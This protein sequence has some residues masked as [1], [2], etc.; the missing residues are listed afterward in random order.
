MVC[1]GIRSLMA[2]IK[3]AHVS[4]GLLLSVALMWVCPILQAQV[5]EHVTAVQPAYTTS[6]R[7]ADASELA[8]DNYSRVA[9]SAV[10][11]RVVLSRDAG[12]LVE[13][14]HW[15]A[16]EATN[17]GQIV[18][19]ADLTD[20]AI[21][22]RLNHDV[23]F[24]SVAT[25][26]LQRYGYLLPATNPESDLAKQQDLILK[27]RARRFVALEGQ[28]DAEAMRPQKNEQPEVERTSDCDP[29][30]DD[31]CENPEGRQIDREH[32]LPEGRPSPDL[33]TPG[34]PDFL[35]SPD[36]SPLPSRTM[37][38]DAG[39]TAFG[40]RDNASQAGTFDFLPD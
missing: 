29:R 7:R 17:N 5:R 31:A 21:F 11:I 39:S 15:I 18:E 6:T 36:L 33:N 23:V 1:L 10:Q 12:L 3:M 24:R 20:E 14:K 8:K 34:M 13:L 9:A 37:R 32:A 19:D 35:Q 25:R 22:E 16:T 40:L 27:E 30:Q 38:A 26:L 28:E 4:R 2:M